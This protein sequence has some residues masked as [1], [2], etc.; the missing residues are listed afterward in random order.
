MYVDMCMKVLLFIFRLGVI[1]LELDFVDIDTE[2]VEA[3]KEKF[4]TMLSL[5]QRTEVTINPKLS[6]F[7]LFLT[8]IWTEK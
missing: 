1:K 6:Y 7:L 2:L 8:K 3:Y 4:Q 5:M